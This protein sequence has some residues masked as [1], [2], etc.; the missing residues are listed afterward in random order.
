MESN[1]P[2]SVFEALLTGN[3]LLVLPEARF[4]AQVG[5]CNGS[6]LIRNGYVTAVGRRGAHGHASAAIGCVARRDMSS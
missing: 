5:I 6:A 3:A 2:R 1:P 4:N